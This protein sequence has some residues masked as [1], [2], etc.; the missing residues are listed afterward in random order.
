[1]LNIIIMTSYLAWS[2]KRVSRL[3]CTHASI[4]TSIVDQIQANV[5][6]EANDNLGEYE[7][8]AREKQK[9]QIYR[10][11]HKLPLIPSHKDGKYQFPPVNQQSEKHQGIW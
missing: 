4:M 9:I 6:C 11:K 2:S 1:V 8:N 7:E 5:T 10:I 3:I